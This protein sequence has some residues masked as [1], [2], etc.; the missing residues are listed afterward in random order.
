MG[1]EKEDQVQ[2]VEAEEAQATK[3]LRLEIRIA[4]EANQWL[5]KLSNYAALEGIIPSDHRGNK[6]AWVNYC[7]GLGEEALKQYVYK[8]R[9]F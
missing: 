8:K 1:E 5:E 4:P 7:L 9:G 2:K 3:V 6:A